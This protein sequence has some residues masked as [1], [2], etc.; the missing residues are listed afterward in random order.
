MFSR[1]AK[2]H[3]S[4]FETLHPGCV[5]YWQETG[6]I[7]PINSFYHTGYAWASRADCL[8]RCLLYDKSII[9]GADTLIWLASLSNNKSLFELITQHPLSTLN[10]NAYLIDYL[11][12]AEN[13]SNVIDSKVSCLYSQVKSLAHGTNKDKKYISR[14]QIL[15][16]ENYDPQKD[17]FYNEGILNLKNKNLEKLIQKYFNSINED[18]KSL[19]GSINAFFDKGLKKEEIASR[20]KKFEKGF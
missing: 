10:L 18:Q 20:Q 6:N 2:Q 5:R 11:N 12:W 4:G 17:V 14:Y 13:W 1:S 8:E 7:L 3:I 16:Q 9:G 19:W 15:Q